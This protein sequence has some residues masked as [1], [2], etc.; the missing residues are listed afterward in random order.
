V[1]S[2][3][4]VGAYES[5]VVNLV[6]FEAWFV[7]AELGIED[8]GER[9]LGALSHGRGERW[10]MSLSESAGELLESNI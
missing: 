1:L 2:E 4:T 10:R 9:S 8:A 3:L 5:R 6:T 7:G